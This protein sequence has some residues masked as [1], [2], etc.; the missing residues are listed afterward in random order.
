M[1]IFDGQA[2]GGRKECNVNGGKGHGAVMGS[3]QQKR[4]EYFTVY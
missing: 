1:V 4:G 2:F 3:E